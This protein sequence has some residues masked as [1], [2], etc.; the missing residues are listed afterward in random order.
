MGFLSEI[1]IKFCNGS[2]HVKTLCLGKMNERKYKYKRWRE[3]LNMSIHVYIT[4]HYR[5][6]KAAFNAVDKFSNILN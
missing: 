4:K 3:I 1:E 2:N 5:N 6:K